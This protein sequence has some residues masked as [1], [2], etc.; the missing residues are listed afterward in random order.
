MPLA[1]GVVY[2]SHYTAKIS[3]FS[4]TVVEAHRVEYTHKVSWL[5][6]KADTLDFRGK[7]ALSEKVHDLI[8]DRACTAIK[9]IGVMDG[10]RPY[11]VVAEQG[12]LLIHLR[13]FIQIYAVK[14]QG[15]SKPVINRL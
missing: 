12:E 5:R 10:Y 9:V 4:K 7:A 14:V 15:I 2:L 6:D 13:E 8:L 3:V 11:A 1:E